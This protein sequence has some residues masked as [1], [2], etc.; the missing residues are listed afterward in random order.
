MEKDIDSWRVYANCKGADTAIFFPEGNS[1][2]KPAKDLCK[3]CFV[4]PECLEFALVTNQ[5]AGIWGGM[6]ERQRKRLRRQRRQAQ[7]SKNTK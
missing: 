5:E 2:Q 6:S 4:K 1:T 3:G 7:A